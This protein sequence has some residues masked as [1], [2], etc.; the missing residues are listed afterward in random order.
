MVMAEEIIEEVEKAWP[1]IEPLVLLAGMDKGGLI[2]AALFEKERGEHNHFIRCENCIYQE[3]EAL[4]KC[5]EELPNMA[6]LWITHGN[7]CPKF[8]PNPDA[9][10]VELHV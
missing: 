10:G 3:C 7:N 9:D 5:K 6:R 1:K 2:V 8:S 4:K